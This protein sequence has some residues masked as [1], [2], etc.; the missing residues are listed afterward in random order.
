MEGKELLNK[1][2]QSSIFYFV[3]IEMIRKNIK[4]K[5]W[6]EIIVFCKKY[7]GWYGNVL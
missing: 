4:I 5:L 6:I 3:S 1:K 7:N 2:N